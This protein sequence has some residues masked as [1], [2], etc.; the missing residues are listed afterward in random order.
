M[1]RFLV[2]IVLL[3][4]CARQTAE[5]QRAVLGGS[6]DTAHAGVVA[7]LLM[8][9]PI[10]ADVCTGLLISPRIVATAAHCA[11]GKAPTS[12]SVRIGA[13]ITSADQTLTPTSVTIYPRFAGLAADA[14]EAN[15]LAILLLPQDANATPLAYDHDGATVS[16]ARLVGFGVA[17]PDAAT[18]SGTRR[19]ADVS[20]SIACD[21]LLS[22]ATSTACSGDSGAPLLDAS[23]K[24]IAIISFGSSEPCGAPAYALRLAP[25][26]AW[27]DTIVAGNPD[28]QCASTCPPAQTSCLPGPP[29]DQGGGCSVV[30]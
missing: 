25:F 5:H 12:I 19:F 27:L 29:P 16:T 20:P 22:I 17:D 10:V 11:F 18:S 3:A 8:R 6:P 23:D 28:S 24:A 26:A 4:G 7:V 2:L 21:R 13:S 30:F 1:R 14:R 9:G 15:D